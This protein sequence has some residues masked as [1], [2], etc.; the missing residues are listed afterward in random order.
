[1]GD[2]KVYEENEVEK[3]LVIVFPAFCFNAD[4]IYLDYIVI[5]IYLL[6]V[7]K[8]CHFKANIVLHLYSFF[9]LLM[10]KRELIVNVNK[11]E[12]VTVFY[13]K[14]LYRFKKEQTL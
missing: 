11:K 7:A 2:R 14:F 8:G 3:K 6:R 5:T 10:I 12:Q 4:C 9:N 13:Y 1:M